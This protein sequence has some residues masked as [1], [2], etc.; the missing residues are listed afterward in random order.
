LIDLFFDDDDDVGWYFSGYVVVVVVVVV[1][2]RW[3][4]SREWTSLY[5][6]CYRSRWE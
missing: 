3:V 2:D 5:A 1:D 4:S 6:V